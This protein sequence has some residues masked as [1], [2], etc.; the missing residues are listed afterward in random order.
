MEVKWAGGPPCNI[1]TPIL[2]AT[3]SA[4]LTEGSRW[5]AGPPIARLACKGYNEPYYAHAIGD[6]GARRELGGEVDLLCKLGVLRRGGLLAAL[7]NIGFVV[8]IQIGRA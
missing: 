5:N 4:F 1:H 6:W 2:V 3:T 7:E 8:V